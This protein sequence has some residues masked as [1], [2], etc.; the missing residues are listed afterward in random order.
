MIKYTYTENSNN[1]KGCICNSN[2]NKNE[3]IM[4]FNIEDCIMNDYEE[5][6]TTRFLLAIKLYKNRDKVDFSKYIEEVNNVNLED[7]LLF[8][9]EDYLN[10]LKNTFMYFMIIKEQIIFEKD[11]ATY[12][13][14]NKELK[15][16]LETF[17]KFYIYAN[18]YAYGY[19]DNCGKT[20]AILTPARIINFKISHTNP[21]LINKIENGIWK[22][23]ANKEYKKGEEIFE[24]YYTMDTNKHPIFPFITLCDWK[25]KSCVKYCDMIEFDEK[26]NESFQS[27]INISRKLNVQELNDI[28][29]IYNF[30]YNEL[31]NLFKY[32]N[33][34]T[35]KLILKLKIYE[36]KLI[37]DALNKVY[38]NDV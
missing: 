5:N 24:C 26:Y 36:Y 13:T 31:T 20:Y 12:L 33:N 37:N 34:K 32:S 35:E 25:L 1:I 9:S 11:Y 6:Y 21:I 23:F 17:K 30:N 7:S 38:I 27:K 29:K 4:E 28:N 16:N 19:Q 10:K 22:I 14:N 15:I 3:L 18:T 2:I 8:I